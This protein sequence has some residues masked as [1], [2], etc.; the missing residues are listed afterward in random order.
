MQSTLG[1]NSREPKPSR[2]DAVISEAGIKEAAG[3]P[4]RIAVSKAEHEKRLSSAGSQESHET[5]SN[6]PFCSPKIGTMTSCS[7]AKHLPV[8]P[9]LHFQFLGSR[10]RHHPRLRFRRKFIFVEKLKTYWIEASEK[11]DSFAE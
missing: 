1:I 7:S 5:P 4:G 6:S 9:R 10:P 3:N 8:P 2:G 11:P